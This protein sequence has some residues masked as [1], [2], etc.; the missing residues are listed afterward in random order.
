MGRAAAWWGRTVRGGARAACRSRPSSTASTP[1]SAAAGLP[2]PRAEHR[3]VEGVHLILKPVA[4]GRSPRRGRD[5]VHR[6]AAWGRDVLGV[7]SLC[8][9]LG[10]GLLAALPPLPPDMPRV[11]VGPVAKDVFGAR[12]RAGARI[13]V[14]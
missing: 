5:A 1:A 14:L 10:L 7:V 3:L 13:R 4:A 2:T 11:R 9:C 8:Q 12:L 6:G